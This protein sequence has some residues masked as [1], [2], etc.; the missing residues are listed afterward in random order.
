MWRSGIW[1][2]IQNDS[3]KY[4]LTKENLAYEMEVVLDRR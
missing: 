3:I 2:E 4:R 1:K